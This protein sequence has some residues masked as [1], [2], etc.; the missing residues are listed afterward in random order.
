M[1][2]ELSKA[3][4]ILGSRAQLAEARQSAIIVSLLEVMRLIDKAHRLRESIPEEYLT[5]LL[6]L[7]PQLVMISG[8]RDLGRSVIADLART[9]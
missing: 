6:A 2:T 1:K 7:A 3:I 9:Q 5:A 4:A 8:Q